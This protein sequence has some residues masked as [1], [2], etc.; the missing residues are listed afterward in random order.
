[1]NRIIEGKEDGC[2]MLGGDFNIRIDELGGS[3]IEEERRE[4]RSK[5]KVIENNGR[6]FV[7]WLTEKWNILNGIT[8]GDWEGEYTYVGARGSTVIDYIVASE[9]LDGGNRI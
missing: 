5:D 1:M 6:N 8:E 2:V 4:R 7:N 9:E 3:G